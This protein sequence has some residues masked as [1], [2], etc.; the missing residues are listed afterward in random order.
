M[1]PYITPF[2]IYIALSLA[3]S[4]FDSGAYWLY[5]VKTLVVPEFWPQLHPDGP[6]VLELRK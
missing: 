2:A 5:P 3:G 6:A 4:Y 1:A